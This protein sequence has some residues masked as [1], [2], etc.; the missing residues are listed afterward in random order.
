VGDVWVPTELLDALEDQRQQIAVTRLA[1]STW[2]DTD[3]MWPNRQGEHGS[4][5][6][7][8]RAF[9]RALEAAGLRRRP[10]HHLRHTC[11]SLLID[12]GETILTVQHQLRHRQASITL[13]TYSHIMPDAGAAALQRLAGSF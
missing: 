4:Q 1:S 2:T 11:A 9:H 3:A 8:I 5:M 12:Q 6:M 13:D 10:F 7:L